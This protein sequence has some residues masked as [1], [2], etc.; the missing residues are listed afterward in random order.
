[1]TI[2]CNRCGSSKGELVQCKSRR[3]CGRFYHRVCLQVHCMDVVGWDA[4]KRH[5]CLNCQDMVEPVEEPTT[6]VVASS[7]STSQTS[8]HASVNAKADTTEVEQYFDRKPRKKSLRDEGDALVDLNI[9]CQHEFIAEVEHRTSKFE[10]AFGALEESFRKQFHEWSFSMATKQSILLYGLGSKSSVL[11]SFGKKLSAEGDVLS[12]NGYDAKVNVG[13]FLGFI[14]QLFC[15][16]SESD[17]EVYPQPTTNGLVKRAASIAKKFSLKRS[18]PLF[19]I[20]HNLDGKGLRSHFAQ[21]AIATLTANSQKDGSPM[22]RIAASVDNVN[23]SFVLWPPT[24]YDKFEWV[25]IP[26]IDWPQE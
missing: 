24:I 7:S 9:P 23:A 5:V 14:D 19:I 12:L 15:D 1:M 26:C 22:I 10:P 11:T 2:R 13:Q 20:I 6:N 8:R 21:D 18:R 4:K 25:S 17:N 16:G 3:N